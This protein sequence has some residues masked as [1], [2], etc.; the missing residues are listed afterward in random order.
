MQV[1]HVEILPALGRRAQAVLVVRNGVNG[2]CVQVATHDV[3]GGIDKAG[4]C[5]G[6]RVVAVIKVCGADACNVAVCVKGKVLDDIAV[7]VGG[8]RDARG[9]SMLYSNLVVCGVISQGNA[10][11]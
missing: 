10:R 6:L 3:A 9:V 5:F 2:M 1:Y 8:V 4:I 11:T 7:G